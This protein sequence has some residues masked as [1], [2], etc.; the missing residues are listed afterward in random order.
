MAFSAK[1]LNDSN[2]SFGTGLATACRRKGGRQQPFGGRSDRWETRVMGIFDAL[3]TAVSGLQ[4]QSFALQNI[5]GNIANSQTTAFKGTGTEFENLLSGQAAPSQQTS[6]SVLA[7]SSSTISVQGNIQATSVATNMA[8]NGDGFFVVEKPTTFNGGVPSFNGVNLYTRRGDFKVQDGYL[9]NGAGYYLMGV[10]IDTKT[11][12]P[13]GSVPAL[14]QF[15]NSFLPAQA[16]SLLNYGA[17]LPTDPTTP[18]TNPNVPGSDLLKPA[19]FIAN[20]LAITAQPPTIIGVGATLTPDAAASLTGTVDT[21]G[22][23]VGAGGGNLI[24]NGVTISFA[25]GQTP[26]Q[27]AAAITGSAAG[28][29]AAVSASTGHLVLTSADASTA[30]DIQSGST[31]SVLT[32]LGLSVAK[33]DPTNLLTQHAAAQGQTMTVQFGVQPATT[34]TFGTG[35]GQIAT[36]AQLNTALTT[37]LNG[38]TGS[39]NPQNGNLTLTSSTLADP[40]AVTGTANPTLFGLQT[41]SA[42]TPSQT[43]IGSDLTAFLNSSVGGGAITAYDQA[44]SPANIQFRW[45]KSDSASLGSG[46]SDTWNLFYET[47]SSATGTQPAWKNVG[48]NFTFGPN[49]VPTPPISNLTMTGVTV[50][51]VA[52]GDLQLTFASGGLTQFADT[53]GTVNV[54]L[55]QQN[56]FAAGAL[57]TLAV[58]GRGRITGSYSNGQTIDIAAITLASFSGE[59]FLLGV[60]G[61]AYAQTDASGVPVYNASGSITPSSLEGSNTDIA[62]QFT[63]LIVTQQAYSANAKVITASNQ[64]LQVVTNM[65]Q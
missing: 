13:V 26:A 49:G 63:K 47:N 55:L 19:Y 54:N 42:R 58:S 9:V 32:G 4:A 60:T 30:I 14:L 27:I 56:G 21:T 57:Q 46:H 29:S 24:I 43:V 34:F 33:T 22:Y 59:S 8:I 52:L 36:M 6:G 1:P 45:A 18:N 50:N 64:M 61:G 25:A 62:D 40:I 12:N 65:V 15:Q 20:P 23:V 2:L 11:H 16:T 3:N 39:I 44:G 5:S 38:G 48:T 7:S 51:G 37:L 10:P 31:A 53:N 41:T 28:V 35:A 17:N